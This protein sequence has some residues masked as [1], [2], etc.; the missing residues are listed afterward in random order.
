MPVRPA[1]IVY[2]DPSRGPI[3]VGSSFD[4]RTGTV[5][6]ELPHF[7]S[8]AAAALTSIV[9]YLA[10]QLASYTSGTQTV[11]AGDLDLGGVL[12][13]SAP[14]FTLSGITIDGSGASRTYTGAVTVTAAGAT[15]NAGAGL[16]GSVGAISGSYTLNG[17]TGLR[18]T[19]TLALTDVAVTVTGLRRGPGRGRQDRLRLPRNDDRS[20]ARRERRIGLARSDRPSDRV[21]DRRD[22]RVR[23]AHPGRR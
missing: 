14:T 17:Q 6:A 7:S 21:P 11:T 20:A 12:T 16:S 3:D 5:T 10:D 15:F 22:P 8:Y 18:G 19:L 1:R 23:L 13:I 2:L 4:A 9:G